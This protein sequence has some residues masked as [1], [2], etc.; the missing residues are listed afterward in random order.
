MGQGGG[1]HLE[2]EHRDSPSANPPIQVNI[3]GDEDADGRLGDAPSQAAAKT[4]LKAASSQLPVMRLE[5]PVTRLCVV[6]RLREP[7]ADSAGSGAESLDASPSLLTSALV[8]E[9]C[10][11]GMHLVSAATSPLLLTASAAQLAALAGNHPDEV[12]MVPGKNVLADGAQHTT[13]HSFP[14]SVW[15]RP[16]LETLQL[17][18]DAARLEAVESD[19]NTGAG[20]LGS[21]PTQH[22]LQLRSAGIT[23]T[24][25]EGLG[26]LEARLS[27]GIALEMPGRALAAPAAAEGSIRGE[28]GAGDGSAAGQTSGASGAGSSYHEPGST[29]SVAVPASSLVLSGPPGIEGGTQAQLLTLGPGRVRCN[30]DGALAVEVE[31]ARGTLPR[32]AAERLAHA[33]LA[34]SRRPALARRAGGPA[35][36]APVQAPRPG[37][38][39]PSPPAGTPSTQSSLHLG[40]F[41]LELQPEGSGLQ[42]VRLAAQAC[43]V[44]WGAG[45]EVRLLTCVCVGSS[46]VQVHIQ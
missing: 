8:L 43:C 19:S 11:R 1:R 5:V 35:P 7:C 18:L 36:G 33:G 21:L 32:S 31:S 17:Q 23:A 24:L 12:Y 38:P 25:A 45:T 15:D 41:E 37:P 28:A 27:G 3:G 44:G 26:A 40:L 34:L 20:A 29:W 9:A 13:T 46:E 14:L 42:G 30:R 2:W 39:T 10:V 16:W 22:R 4:N 6:P